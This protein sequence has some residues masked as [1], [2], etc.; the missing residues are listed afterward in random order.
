LRPPGVAAIYTPLPN[1]PDLA[2][3]WKSGT[4]TTIVTWTGRLQ[5]TNLPFL[6]ECGRLSV[7]MT[8]HIPLRRLVEI[9]VCID[10]LCPVPSTKYQLRGIHMKP[11]RFPTHNRWYSGRPALCIPQSR[12]RSGAYNSRSCDLPFAVRG[13]DGVGP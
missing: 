5:S 13:S 3:S 2:V 11:T 9:L 4:G 8:T 10:A 6:S 1:F 7:G 12:Y